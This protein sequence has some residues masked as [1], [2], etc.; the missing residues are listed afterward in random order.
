M[1]DKISI[2]T[3]LKQVRTTREAEKFTE[4]LEN[5][6]SNLYKVKNK[7][8]DQVLSKSIGTS[9]SS[10]IKTLLEENKVLASDLPSCEKL[11][12]GVREEI[13]SMNV[14]KITLAIDPSDEIIAHLWDFINQNFGKAL[15]D[16]ELNE[17]ILGGAVI[18]IN[19][20]YKDFSLR[21]SLEEIFLSRKTEIMDS[22]S[23]I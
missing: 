3:I 2:D 17:S 5:I 13:K 8:L 6:F 1:N 16:L 23:S 21:K 14:I 20:K 9:S 10:L 11:L 19:G 15:I 18:S 22:L 7:N 4:D 12:G